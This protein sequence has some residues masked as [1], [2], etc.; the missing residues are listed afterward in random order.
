MTTRD[1]RLAGVSRRAVAYVRGE[2]AEDRG[3]GSQDGQRQAIAR[4]AEDRGLQLV[5]EYIDR[6]AER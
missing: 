1:E 4:Y 3:C 6:E 5:G 2:S